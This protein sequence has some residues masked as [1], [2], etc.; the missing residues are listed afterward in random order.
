M[1][2][3]LDGWRLNLTFDAAH[4]IADYS[5]CSRLHGHEY[6]V[7]M[8]IKGEAKN[9]IIVDFVAVKN[10]IR[11]IIEEL[12]H[13]VIIPTKGEIEVKEEENEVEV[14]HKNKRFVFP[15]EDC[16]LLPIQS[17]SAENLASYILKRFLASFQL[18]SNIEEIGIGVDEGYGQGAWEWR[19]IK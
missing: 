18:P 1:E 4:F 10:E 13:R 14:R 12:D 16:A 11:K 15:K 7:S 9:G 3:R 6:A 5:K 17:S 2:I 19:K 8:V